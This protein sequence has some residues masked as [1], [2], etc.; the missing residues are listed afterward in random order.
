[1][2]ASIKNGDASASGR[3]NNAKAANDI[4]IGSIAGITPTNCL[5]PCASV[6]N[7]R[8]KKMK[9][10][11]AAVNCGPANA[12]GYDNNARAVNPKTIGRIAGIAPTNC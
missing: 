10:A 5:I 6:I 2:D 11:E 7:A 9:P 3:A 1:M 4:T 8:L 12:S